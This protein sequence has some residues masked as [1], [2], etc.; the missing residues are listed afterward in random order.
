VAEA[1][2]T[3]TMSRAHCEALGRKFAE[4]TVAQAPGGGAALSREAAGVGQTFADRC[5]RE[6]VGQSV[7]VREY[8]CI[9]RAQAPEALLGCKR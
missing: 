3:M 8:E 7:E 6:M 9:L 5:G 1:A 4:L 2:G